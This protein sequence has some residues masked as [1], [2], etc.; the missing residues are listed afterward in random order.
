MNSNGP[1][2]SGAGYGRNLCVYQQ[3][4]HAEENGN[5]CNFTG[6]R[7]DSSHFHHGNVHSLVMTPEALIWEI[8]CAFFMFMNTVLPESLYERQVC[9]LV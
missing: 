5:S 7:R 1:S 2:I 3:K 9:F 4:G 6:F 8:G